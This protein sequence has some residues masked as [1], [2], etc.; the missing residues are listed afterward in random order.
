M[1]E[2]AEVVEVTVTYISHLEAGRARPAVPMT[3]R[4]ADA[5]KIDRDEVLVLA[6]HVPAD[7]QEMMRRDPLRAVNAVREAFAT[8]ERRARGGSR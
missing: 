7:V 6:G 8:Y 2:V 4:L 5:L 1:R 3:E